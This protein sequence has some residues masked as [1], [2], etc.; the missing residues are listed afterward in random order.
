MIVLGNVTVTGT[1]ARGVP[2]P[3]LAGL[4]LSCA[5]GLTLVLGSKADGA[6]L[7][8]DLA[9]GVLAPKRGTATLFDQRASSMRGHVARVGERSLLPEH[10][11]V[12]ATLELAWALRAEALG[13][14]A[15]APSTDERLARFALGHLASA[16]V[17]SL[18]LPERRALAFCEALTGLAP[19]LVLSEPLAHV[20]AGALPA[21]AETLRGRVD[22]GAVVL[23]TAL[24][25]RGLPVAKQRLSLQRGVLAPALAAPQH[26]APGAIRV[27][28]TDLRPLTQVLAVHPDV[29]QMLWTD[30]PSGSPPSTDAAPH[31]VL[32]LHGPSRLALAKALQA[33]A[34]AHG[35]ALD[36]WELL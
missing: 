10:A 20:A 25:D 1:S 6:E 32:T 34:T 30:A 33:A 14:T 23:V 16:Q 29:H 18:E 28:G 9:A 8:G 35:V 19:V 12:K 22:D 11:T 27:H 31:A 36:Q 3:R 13:S 5:A 7:L 24:S 4:S 26:D 2:A 17:R 15:S 21:I